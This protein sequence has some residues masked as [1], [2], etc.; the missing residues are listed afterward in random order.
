MVP[1]KQGFTLVE[2][3][4]AVLILTIGLL[5]LAGSAVIVS[6]MIARGQR[7][8]A[9]VAFAARRLE[10]LRTTGCT[11]QASGADVQFRGSSPIDSLSWEFMDRG[12]GG[13]RIVLRSSYLTDGNRWRSDSTE[14]AISCL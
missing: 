8:G 11:T 2:L 5:G 6:R 1:A 13:W 9:H 10:M 7:S 14:T 3:V 12:N 4:I